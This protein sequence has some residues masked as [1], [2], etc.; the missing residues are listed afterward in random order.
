MSD[1]ILCVTEGEKTEVNII[2]RLQSVFSNKKIEIICFG[3]NIYQLYPK[4]KDED[5]HFLDTF[6]LLQEISKMNKGNKDDVLSKYSRNDISEIYLFFDLDKHDNLASTYPNCFDEM[7]EIFDNETENGKLYVS[8][9]MVE[10]F[11]HIITERETYDISQGSTYKNH[12]SK[13]CHQK[14]EK[15]Y[16]RP[17]NRLEWSVYFLEHIKATNFL[18]R[19]SFSYPEKYSDVI[20]AFSQTSIYKNQCKKFINVNNHVLILS[21]FASFLL[22]YLGEPLFNEWLELTQNS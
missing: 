6:P 19:D 1:I 9:P 8:Y 14:L 10:S 5:P 15:F 16:N 20:D 13:N 11:K 4:V 21:P 12:V 17:L 2:N 18:I 7:L 22:E 3:T